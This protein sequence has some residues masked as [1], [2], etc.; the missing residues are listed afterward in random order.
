[1]AAFIDNCGFVPTAGG[2][3]DWTY[4]TTMAGGYM[5][6]S[7]AGAVNSRPYAVH[8]YSSDH[9]QWEIAEGNYSSSGAGSFARTTVLYNSSGTGTK[10]GGAGTKINFSSAPSVVVIAEKRSMLSVAEANEFTATEKAQARANIAA[11][12]KGHLYGLTL[13][14]AG[15]SSTFSVAAGEAADS[16]ASDLMVLAASISKTTS[17]WAVGSGNGGLDTGTIAN[18]T[19]YHA[20]QIKRPDTGVVDVLISTSASAPTLPANY[21]LFRRIGSMKTNGSSQWISF[22]QV[23]DTFTWASAVND[24]SGG[25]W[26]T[27]AADTVLTVPTGVAVEAFGTAAFGSDSGVQY[28]A[29][30]SKSIADFAVNS[31]TGAFAGQNA[32]FR[33]M[34]YFRIMTDILATI[35]RRSSDA[36]G[37]INLYTFGWVDSRGRLG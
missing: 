32:V 29:L 19:W 3:T 27:T 30:Y 8:A 7:D 37:S 20:H 13:S 2:T 33:G 36:N 1:M 18:N 34:N 4:S 5:S 28:A 9:S 35:R 10:Q 17:A 6:P 24:V 22:T 11:A 21:T 23:G 12:L 31:N 16:T 26:T 25:T 15:S 14:T